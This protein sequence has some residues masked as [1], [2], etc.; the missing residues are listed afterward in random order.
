M[1][2]QTLFI[3]ESQS[4]YDIFA[5]IEE[6]LNFKVIY[7]K[8][9]EISKMDFKNYNDYL[10]LSLKNLNLSNTIFIDNLPIR[11]SKLLEKIN[12]E[13]LRKNFNEKSNINVNKYTINTNSREMILLNQKLKLTEKEINMIIY[14]S[15]NK[16]PIKV[17]ELQE[18][19]WGYQSKLETHTVET[20]IH[21][22]R[23]KIK[24][25]FLDENLI[26]SKKNGYQISEKK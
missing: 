7:F 18:K 21:R 26:V 19:V 2:N 5:E 8:D 15:R 13:F 10:I 11:F 4:L 3:Y 12:I 22:L 23:K 6:Y 17:T 16:K 24:E 1:N 14:L 9:K 25:K 20:H